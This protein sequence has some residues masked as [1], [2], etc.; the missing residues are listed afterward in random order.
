MRKRLVSWPKD[1]IWKWK[2]SQKE[3]ICNHIIDKGLIPWKYIH[4]FHADTF[5][6]KTK[7]HPVENQAEELNQNFTKEDTQR[8]THTHQKQVLS[9]IIHQGNAN[10]NNK[11][12][13]WT[14]W[15]KLKWPQTVSVGHDEVQ[16]ELSYMTVGSRY[17][18]TVCEK[19]FVIYYKFAVIPALWPSN[20]TPKYML[21]RN[22]NIS[23]PQVK[24]KYNPSSTNQNTQTLEQQIHPSTEMWYVCIM[25]CHTI[26]KMNKLLPC[27]TWMDLTNII[28]SK[29]H[30]DKSSKQTKIQKQAKWIF[31]FGRYWLSLGKSRTN[32]RERPSRRFSSSWDVGTSM[33]VTHMY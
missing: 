5:L 6:R 22:I 11:K 24:Y 13:N 23:V 18:L 4:F 33:V 19:Q 16:V 31:V 26:T 20:P 7:A 25:K 15:I 14:E 21:N 30:R 28:L 17:W 27:T 32:D 2:A 1:I 8:A 9:L 29:R 12:T 10:K 3:D